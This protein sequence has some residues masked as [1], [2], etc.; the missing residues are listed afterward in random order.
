MG[1]CLWDGWSQWRNRLLSAGDG[2]FSVCCGVGGEEES[3]EDAANGFIEECRDVSGKMGRRNV[4]AQ[5][6]NV[7]HR[8]ADVGADYVVRERSGVR[9]SQAVRTWRSGL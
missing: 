2:R 7:V 4:Y 8:G 3:L 1:A 5:A 9:S 6:H